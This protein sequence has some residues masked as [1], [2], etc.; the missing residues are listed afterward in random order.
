V[1]VGEGVGWGEGEGWAIE[2]YT[3]SGCLCWVRHNVAEG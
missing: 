2:K 1:S 3:P